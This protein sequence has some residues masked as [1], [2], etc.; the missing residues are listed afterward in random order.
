MKYR[1]NGQL[2]EKASALRKHMTKEER[3]LWFEFLHTLPVRI[4]RQKMIGNYIVDFYCAAKKIAVE[5]DGGQHYEEDVI[6]YDKQRDNYLRELGI[7]VV[8]YS[9][10]DVNTNFCGVCDDIMR[11]L[12][13]IE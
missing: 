5:L 13:L 8:R 3:K 6:E 2:K 9:N 12:S 10:R 7:T 1:Y 11:K 4:Y